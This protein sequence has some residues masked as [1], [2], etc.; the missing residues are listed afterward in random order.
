MG[1]SSAPGAPQDAI[2]V[3][4]NTAAGTSWRALCKA[5]LSLPWRRSAPAEILI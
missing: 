5:S 2:G 4:W 1:D 3:T